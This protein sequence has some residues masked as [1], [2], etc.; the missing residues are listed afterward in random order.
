M[1]K[2]KIYWLVGGAVALLG[3]WYLWSKRKTASAPTTQ[4]T[5]EP[6]ETPSGVKFGSQEEENAFYEAME[7]KYAIGGQPNDKDELSTTFGTYYFTKTGY[8][9]NTFQAQGYWTKYPTK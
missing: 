9:N 2:K 6:S 7:A 8:D 1:D 4:T 3:G 5:S